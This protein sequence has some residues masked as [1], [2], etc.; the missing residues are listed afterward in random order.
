MDA[1]H[2]VF[3]ILNIFVAVAFLLSGIDDLFID[4]YYWVRELY[5]KIALRKRIQP[6]THSDL[7]NE[8]EKWTA[9]WIP[10]WHEHEV[11]DKMVMNT[12]EAVEYRNY[13][14]F[15][16]VYPQPFVKVAQQLLQ[17]LS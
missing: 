4:I 16:G 13:D 5:R 15:V 8:P 17:Y 3:V 14:I 11:I 7:A 9:I 12:L 1:L 6:V 10:A 2:N